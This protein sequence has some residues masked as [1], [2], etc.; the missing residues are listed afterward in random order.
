MSTFNFS[1]DIAIYI[2]VLDWP[3][4]SRPWDQ[5]FFAANRSER[6]SWAPFASCVPVT[7]GCWWTQ[8]HPW[9]FCNRSS[10]WK[11][12]PPCR[13]APPRDWACWK[14]DCGGPGSASRDGRWSRSQGWPECWC[15]IPASSRQPDGSP[16]A[17]EEKT[18]MYY[19]NFNKLSKSL[20]FN[21]QVCRRTIKS[22]YMY[23]RKI[24]LNVFN[25]LNQLDI[26]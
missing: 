1:I 3:P 17:V 6:D 11:S 12:R 7:C 9:C 4:I 10:R 24:L 16:A 5:F 13:R 15:P 20:W 8:R 18:S 26:N 25:C 22:Y 2:P 21:V 14:R 23:L 19:Q